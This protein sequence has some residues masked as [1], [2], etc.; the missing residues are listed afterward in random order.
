MLNATELPFDFGIPTKKLKDIAKKMLPTVSK[1]AIRGCL[2][3]MQIT[4]KGNLIT[5]YSTDAH[6]L[7]EFT[8]ESQG[9]D[10]NVLIHRDYIE[11]LKKTGELAGYK[12]GEEDDKTGSYPDCSRLIPYFPDTVTIID[13]KQLIKDIGYNRLKQHTVVKLDLAKHDISLTSLNSDPRKCDYYTVVKADLDVSITKEQLAQYY[14]SDLWV[15]DQIAFNIN[16]FLDA[17]K[18]IGS[19]TI[20][21]STNFHTPIG[22]KRFKNPE[23][24]EFSVYLMPAQLRK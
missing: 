10:Y 15:T 23:D 8:I 11:E 22:L 6:R 12:V 17:L 3:S 2:Q 21:V 18:A 20:Q 9:A 1:E 24:K 5:A 7:S 16:Y 4:R 14:S 19:D 13:A